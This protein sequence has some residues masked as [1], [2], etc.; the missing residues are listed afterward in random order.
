MKY[1]AI[2]S[3]FLSVA[4]SALAAT[5]WDAID[6]D[7]PHS[8]GVQVPLW[9]NASLSMQGVSDSKSGTITGDPA[10]DSRQD[11][12]YADGFNRLNSA[13]NPTIAGTAASELFPRTTY[14]GF[15]D[16]RQVVPPSFSPSGNIPGSLSLHDVTLVGGQYTSALRN[17][18]QN[19]GVELFYR[20]RW[21]NPEK[22]TLD[23]EAGMSWQTFDWSQSGN[24][25]AVA[26]VAEDRYNTGTV[27][28]RVFP[29]SG[30]TLP[31][32]GPFQPVGGTPWIG[33]VPS[34][35]ATAYLPAS[36]N[37]TRDLELDSWVGRIG[38]AAHWRFHPRWRLGAL[39]GLAVGYSDVTYSFRDQISVN[40]PTV[41]V[42]VQQGQG[43]YSDVWFGLYSALRLTYRLSERWDVLVEGRHIWTD[44][45]TH[46]ASGRV[47]R[48]DLSE[49]V[50]VS[51]GVACRF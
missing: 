7:K 28:P 12:F 29:G 45:Q 22:W 10:V 39:V 50:G 4:V 6:H 16:N 21:K 31:Y 42:L 8:F 44:A 18:D 19:P 14:F 3:A 17:G 11:R 5:D 37:S 41:P 1:S 30:G 26:A 36:V 27:D 47:F 40:S 34:R 38:P 25:D 32:S 35:Q 48:L 24:V 9:F 13:G 51:V 2:T 43:G 20:Y 15:Q 49:G 33:S 46:T 23:L